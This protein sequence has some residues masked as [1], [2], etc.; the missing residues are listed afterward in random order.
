LAWP[1][2]VSENHLARVRSPR[3]PD[4]ARSCAGQMVVVVTIA[5]GHCRLFALNKPPR[6][7]QRPPCACGAGVGGI[8]AHV[9]IGVVNR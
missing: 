4:W 3:R 7:G 6:A 8:R 5:G 1:G 2:W 9:H